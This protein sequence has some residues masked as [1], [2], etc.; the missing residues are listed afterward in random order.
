MPCSTAGADGPQ[1]LRCA[2]ASFAP[3]AALPRA[4]AVKYAVLASSHWPTPR[5]VSESESRRTKVTK[6]GEP[7]DF[8]LGGVVPGFQKAIGGQQVGSTVAVVM[9]S[10]DGYA[11][12]QPAAGIQKGQSLVFSIKILN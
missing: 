8:P 6:L 12:G 5:G 3:S 4:R 9:A 7:V 11:D 10:A 2:P 1:R